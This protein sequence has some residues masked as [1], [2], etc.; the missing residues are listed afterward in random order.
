MNKICTSIEQSKKLIELGIDVNTADMYWKN[1][2][3]DR[4]IQCFTPFVCGDYQNGINFDYDI[5]AWSLSALL[6]LMPTDDKRDEYYVDIESHSD[7][8]TVSYRNC[9]DGCIYSE[10][11]EESLLDAAFEMTCWLLENKKIQ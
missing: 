2:V 3:S 1:G 11:S 8:H 9:W 10:V 5:P 4:Y 7:Y 6:G